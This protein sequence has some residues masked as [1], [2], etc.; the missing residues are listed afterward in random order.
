MELM[1]RTANTAFISYSHLEWENFA[2]G[3]DK[4]GRRPLTPRHVYAH[5][6]NPELNYAMTGMHTRSRI[7]LLYHGLVPL[8]YSFRVPIAAKGLRTQS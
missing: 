5:L 2:H 8:D 6:I 4:S 1:S 7:V 3:T